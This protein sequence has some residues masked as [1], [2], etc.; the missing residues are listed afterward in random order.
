M[1]ILTVISFITLPLIVISSFF[2]MNID[3]NSIAFKIIAGF[4]LA[5]IVITFVSAKK[6]KWL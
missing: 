1:Q 6:K 2:N 4:M 3:L 5:S